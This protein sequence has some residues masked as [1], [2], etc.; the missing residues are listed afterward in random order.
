[1]AAGSG[2]VILS[3]QQL[4]NEIGSEALAGCV[5]QCRIALQPRTQHVSLGMGAEGE[6]RIVPTSIRSRTVGRQL[7]IRPE[8][9]Q[10]AIRIDEF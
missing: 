10:H 6:R 5:L 4:G 9:V 7:V 2:V 3:F 8:Y 1:M